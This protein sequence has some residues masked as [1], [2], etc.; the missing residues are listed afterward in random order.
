MG[1][2]KF[3]LAGGC[4]KGG[5]GGVGGGLNPKQRRLRVGGGRSEKGG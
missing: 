5:V 2:G 4:G 3:F 1:I